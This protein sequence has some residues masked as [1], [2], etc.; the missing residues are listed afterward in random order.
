MKLNSDGAAKSPSRLAS[1]GGLLRDHR[2]NWIAGYTCNIGIA[3]SFL[4]EL[5]GLREGLLLAKNRG[6][7]KLIAE[8]DSE[9]MVQV[10]RRDGMSTINSN[11]LVTD[12]KL[13]LDHFQDSKVVHIFREGNQCADYLAN[14][15]QSSPF[16]TTILDHPPEGLTDFLQR[17]ASGLAFSRRH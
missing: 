6:I 3:N 10:L 1:A 15:G 16:G 2:G 17:D 14:I 9:T 5:W 13:L 12:C 11:V 8:T 7:S 4:A